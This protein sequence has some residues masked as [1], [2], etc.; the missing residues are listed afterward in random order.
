MLPLDTGVEYVVAENLRLNFPRHEIAIP[1]TEAGTKLGS[2]FREIA[3]K[4]NEMHDTFGLCGV[5]AVTVNGLLAN[6]NA[7]Q[8]VNFDPVELKTKFDNWSK[9]HTG[10]SAWM[11]FDKTHKNRFTKGP[12][13]FAVLTETQLQQITPRLDENKIKRVVFDVARWQ[14]ALHLQEENRLK[15]PDE[16]LDFVGVTSPDLSRI[17]DQLA[18]NEGI[19]IAV[20]CKYPVQKGI[21]T[22]WLAA[23]RQSDGNKLL[24]AGDLKPF[25][26]PAVGISVPIDDTLKAMGRVIGAS[27][28]TQLTKALAESN[29]AD[30]NLHNEKMF[31]MNLVRRRF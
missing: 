12:N 26:I 3:E 31:L 4:V 10:D 18:D 6:P 14:D 11:W 20:L 21:H 2:N 29:T 30:R 15:P 13:D 9:N 22:H 27:P 7:W 25:G 17:F 24:I 16:K 1:F 5:L 23:R 8:D 19:D 28:T